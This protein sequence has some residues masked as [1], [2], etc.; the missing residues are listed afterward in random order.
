MAV[1]SCSS[2]HIRG[3]WFWEEAKGK[4]MN[5][6]PEQADSHHVHQPALTGPARCSGSL[7]QASNELDS[8]R[9]SSAWNQH[10]FGLPSR[11]SLGRQVP[12]GHNHGSSREGSMPPSCRPTEPESAFFHCT[13]PLLLCSATLY[14]NSQRSAVTLLSSLIV[15]HQHAGLYCHFSFAPARCAWCS[16]ISASFHVT[17][18]ARPR[19]VTRQPTC[20]PPPSSSLL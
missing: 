13:E 11:F 18:P 7:K 16:E 12:A 10:L 3:G 5:G 8:V 20:D 17:H 19:R 1:C 2:C 4:V 15:L 9:S 14:P 6:R